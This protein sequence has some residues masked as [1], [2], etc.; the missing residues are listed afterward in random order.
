MPPQPTTQ[1]KEDDPGW[2]S[3]REGDTFQPLNK[4]VE[5][6]I[7]TKDEFI[8]F[9]DPKLAVHYWYGGTYP[10]DKLPADFG[11]VLIEES[12]LEAISDE[13]LR[14]RQKRVFRTLLG[15]SIAR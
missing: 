1:K 2:R 6:L 15:E 13:L 7:V 10:Y 9:L 3:V 12:K 5:V 11:K 4:E 8:V 14:K